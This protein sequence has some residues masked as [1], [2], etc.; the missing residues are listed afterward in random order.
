MEISGWDIAATLAK[1][2]TY[3]ATF[4]AAGAVL[5]LF[6][7][8]ALLRDRQRAL[9]R[10]LIGMLVGV[11]A[12]ASVLRV[13]LLAGSMSGEVAGMFNGTFTSMIL[14]AGEGRATGQRIAG[15]ALMLFALSTNRV[16]SL[17]AI[18]GAIAA[19]TS[20]AWV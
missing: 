7:C 15:L 6:Y 10:R 11:A 18:L 20:F 8:R 16:L 14:G 19:S 13:L 1:A 9:I 12:T 17:S 2:V 4:G 5:F 3:A